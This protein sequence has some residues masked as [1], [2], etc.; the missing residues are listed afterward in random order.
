MSERHLPPSPG[1]LALARRAGLFVRSPLAGAGCVLAAVLAGSDV[2][3]RVASGVANVAAAAW[4]QAGQ[5]SSRDAWAVAMRGVVTRAGDVVPLVGSAMVWVAAAGL[6]AAFV[7]VGP[8]WTW[9]AGD[10]RRR[11]GM[12]PEAARRGRRLAAVVCTLGPLAVA[13]F[14]LWANRAG[15]ADVAAREA[16]DG[17]RVVGRSLREAGWWLAGGLLLAGGVEHV[18]GRLGLRARLKMTREEARREQAEQGGRVWRGEGAPVL[19]DRAAVATAAAVLMG[20]G[21]AVAIRYEGREGEVPRGVAAG[22]GAR[23]G[24]LADLAAEAGVATV[25]VEEAAVRAMVARGVGELIEAEQYGVVGEALAGGVAGR[26]GR[27]VDA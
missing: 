19:D 8:A 15:L 2:L 20:D 26:Q 10:A 17:A 13:G 22:V 27:R 16:A 21:V 14:S 5:T 23:A 6:F 25:Q 3:E 18:A 11:L 1:R 7:Q 4:S 9:G 12:G 24:F